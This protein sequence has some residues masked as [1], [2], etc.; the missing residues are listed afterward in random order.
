V[1]VIRNQRPD[2]GVQVLASVCRAEPFSDGGPVN[3]ANLQIVDELPNRAQ[4]NDMSDAE[5]R[6]FYATQAAAILAALNNALPGGTLDAL[7]AAMA[8]DRASIF[9]VAHR[10]GEPLGDGVVDAEVHEADCEE[11]GRCPACLAQLRNQ[12]AAAVAIHVP[13]HG[14]E[15]PP[16]GCEFG[17][18]KT[19]QPALCVTCTF[20]ERAIAHPCPTARALGVVVPF[21]SQESST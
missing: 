10:Y 14:P 19:S 4:R 15:L 1:T 11:R 2:G 12:R 9:R 6:S 13:C 20:A 21:D 8:A 7:F 18:R 17:H 16:L 3:T 5:L